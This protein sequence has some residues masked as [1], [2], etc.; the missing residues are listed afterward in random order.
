VLSSHSFDG[1][2]LV[3]RANCVILRNNYSHTILEE[4]DLCIVFTLPFLPYSA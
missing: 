3:R 4:G 2:L 1:N